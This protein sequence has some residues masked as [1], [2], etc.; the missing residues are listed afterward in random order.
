MKE[1]WDVVTC[2]GKEDRQYLSHSQSSGIVFLAWLLKF[3][4]VRPIWRAVQVNCGPWPLQEKQSLQ[5]GGG[6]KTES[7]KHNWGI[8]LVT[9]AVA[10]GGQQKSK[11]NLA[12]L[13]AYAYFP[14]LLFSIRA[15]TNRWC[16]VFPVSRARRQCWIISLPPVIWLRHF[17][18]RADVGWRCWQEGRCSTLGSLWEDVRSCCGVGT[19]L[20][21][22]ALG[23]RYRHIFFLN[24]SHLKHTRPNLTVIIFNTSDGPSG[25]AR[26]ILLWKNYLQ[27]IDITAY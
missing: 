9:Q 4:T 7:K 23:R 8:R 20:F 12:S 13:Q 27:K 15:C 18:T 22:I 14:M 5:T 25:Q 3:P 21:W 19:C 1:R 6:W 11:S 2:G 17:H 26:P 10:V 16:T 24:L